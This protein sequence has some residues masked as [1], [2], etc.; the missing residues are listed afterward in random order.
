MAVAM[1]LASGCVKKSNRGYE[2]NG[3]PYD[4]IYLGTDL[5]EIAGNIGDNYPWLVRLYRSFVKKLATDPQQLISSLDAYICGDVVTNGELSTQLG[6]KPFVKTREAAD[7]LMPYI[8]RMP[9][10]NTK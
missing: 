9:L 7:A 1:G 4:N 2:L 8:R 10:D 5:E 6:K 3:Q